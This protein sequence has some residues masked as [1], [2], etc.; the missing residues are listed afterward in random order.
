M[1]IE[2]A[3]APES[4]YAAIWRLMSGNPELLLRHLGGYVLLV[5]EHGKRQAQLFKATVAR[6]V[7]A[8]LAL[9]T[10]AVG[11]E[12]AVMLWIANPALATTSV[13]LLFALP[14]AALGIAVYFGMPRQQAYEPGLVDALNFQLQADLA[15]LEPTVGRHECQ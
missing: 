13:L 12:V 4:P 1:S 3:V 14:C 7:G 6:Q 5:E 15:L 10:G 2:Q 11:I 8:L 9:G